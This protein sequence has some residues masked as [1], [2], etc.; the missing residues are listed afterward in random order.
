[1]DSED[2]VD[3]LASLELLCRLSKEAMLSAKNPTDRVK[4]LHQIEITVKSMS[5]FSEE[6]QS[7]KEG[8]RRSADG[9]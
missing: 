6:Y 8:I 4:A 5:E 1:M 9:I 7:W 3:R 2:I